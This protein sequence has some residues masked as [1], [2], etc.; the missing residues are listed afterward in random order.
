M[1]ICEKISY[2]KGLAEGLELDVGDDAV[3]NLEED[4]HDIAAL[5]VADRAD[6]GSVLNLANVAGIG[7]VIHHFFRIHIVDLLCVVFLFEVAVGV[8]RRHGAQT[9]DDLGQLLQHIVDLLFCGFAAQREAQ[10]T[11][12][13][14]M[15]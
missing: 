13:N 12:R 8:Q 10:R 1:D 9:L 5:G 14:F 15:R 6:A 3:L 4:A 2:I 7:E 11:V